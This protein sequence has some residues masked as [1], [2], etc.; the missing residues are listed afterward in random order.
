MIFAVS[1]FAALL[2]TALLVGALL[3]V[4]RRYALARPNARSSH[5][6]PTPQGAGIAIVIA[7]IGV[8][9]VAAIGHAPV[10]P[11]ELTGLAVLAGASVALAIIGA[12]D[13]LR[14]LGA[15]PRLAMQ[16]ACVAAVVVAMPQEMRALPDL[17]LALERGLAV[18]AGVWFVNLTNFMDGLDLMT[19]AGIGPAVAAI[20]LLGAYGILPEAPALVAAAL[21]G[22]LAGFAPW[23]RP[24]ARV[25]LGDVGSLPIGLVTGYCLYALACHGHLVA[26]L[27]LPAYYLTDATVT[28][29]RR[30]ARGE[31]FWEAH[32]SHFYQ[33]ATDLGWRVADV[34]GRV[35]LTNLILALLAVVST[36][37]RGH[38]WQLVALLGAAGVV[39]LLL[40]R[41][42]AAPEGRRR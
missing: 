9:G 5:R 32:R 36:T 16:T 12:W 29:V 4:L 38:E 30:M 2:A 7:V 41:L 17:P 14:P 18:L 24:V 1:A 31:R 15:L 35:F 40:S 8:V 25:F 23:N 22:A 37:T 19:V 26:A 21:A 42:S 27:V 6:V 39:L 20:A 28:L 33:R 34:S 10:A 13:D 3:P 11:R